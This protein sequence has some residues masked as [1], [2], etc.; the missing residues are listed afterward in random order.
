M[1]ATVFEILV[2]PGDE[3]QEDDELVLLESMKMQI[4]VAAPRQGK[5]GAIHVEQ[6]QSIQ[7]DDLLLTLE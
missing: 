3:V 7:E 1:V 5:V 4:P 6:G 2:E